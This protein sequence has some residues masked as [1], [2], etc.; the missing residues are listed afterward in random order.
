MLN[1]LMKKLLLLCVI[2]CLVL[3]FVLIRNS[4][5]TRDIN[6]RSDN[7]S[8]YYFTY[9][10]EDYYAEYSGGE[11]TVYNSY[12]I[13][14]PKDIKTICTALSEEHPVYA[15]DYESYRTPSDMAF[16]W[17]QHSLAYEQLPEGNSWRQSAKNVT[18]DPEDQGKTFKEIYEDRTGK[19][20]DIDM[21]L[22]HKDKISSK[23][24]EYLR[25]I[26]NRLGD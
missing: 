2:L 5:W 3:F 12:R 17:V 26:E 11:W 25:K 16:E 13:K 23:I 1:R 9:K 18:L 19:E 24:E 21:V 10:G 14:N 7:D 6:L 4:G 15:S 20:L 22:S 8:D